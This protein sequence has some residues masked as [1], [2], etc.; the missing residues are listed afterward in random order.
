MTSLKNEAWIKKQPELDLFKRLRV[1]ETIIEMQEVENEKLKDKINKLLV[2][3]EDLNDTVTQLID[4]LINKKT[5]SFTDDNIVEFYKDESPKEFGK[6]LVKIRA[7][8]IHY[9]PDAEAAYIAALAH[10]KD[11]ETENRTTS[12][13]LD[14]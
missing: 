12:T 10:Q 11:V 7:G 3:K 8:H 2:E 4:T 1:L 5:V 6:W 9:C 13:V 14:S